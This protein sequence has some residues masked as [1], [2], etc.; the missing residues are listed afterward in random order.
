MTFGEAYR[1]M[2]ASEKMI[3]VFKEALRLRRTAFKGDHP[4]LA[5]SLRGLAREYITT[6]R[7]KEAEPLALESLAIYRRLY[8]NSHERVAVVLDLLGL[9]SVRATNWA[10]AEVYY[11]EA[12][13][14]RKALDPKPSRVECP[15]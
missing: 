13:A 6:Y 7:T 8:G 15:P 1:K 9:T 12:I 4:D 2:G 10:A 14:V 11:R 5:D 3:I